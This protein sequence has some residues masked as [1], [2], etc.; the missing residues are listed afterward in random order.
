[1]PAV[2]ILGLLG[3]LAL[4]LLIGLVELPYQALSELG[5]QLQR[6]LWPLEGLGEAS[7]GSWWAVALVFGAT[8]ALV[9]L[10]AGPW[11]RGGGGGLTAALALQQ[12]SSEQ[13][14]GLLERIDLKTQ[15]YRLPLMALAH[16]GGLTVG[17]ESP[18]AA[19]G[20]SLVLAL[21]GRC[22]GL[23]HLPVK[24]LAAMGG[25]AGL[26][27][28]FRSPLLGALYV[29]EEL[30]REQAWS[31]VLPTL[32]LAGAGSLASSSLGQPARLVVVI[33]A[34]FPP[35]WW[36]WALVL[37][38]LA[39]VLGACFVRLLIPLARWMKTTL[40]RAPLATAIGVAFTLSMLAL[41]SGGLSLNDGSLSLAAALQGQSGGSALTFLWRYLAGL[42]SIA[43]GAPGGLMHDVMTLGALLLEPF[44]GLL[45]QEAFA[46]MAAIGAAALFAAA[47]GTPLFSGAFVFTLQ[48]NAQLLPWLLLASA[49]ASAIAEPLRG[50]EWN[51]YQV[52]VLLNPRSG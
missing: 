42:V 51:A 20:A 27:A 4:G 24:L 29:V 32:L 36:G 15:L 46:P 35:Q 22:P 47:N 39:A 25:G 3:L 9:L 45:P 49:L 21:R 26:G 19:L 37:I 23:G 2:G 33:Q 1:M 50:E 48:G 5:F 14:A 10:T 8:L 16:G 40:L 11:R 34:P 18:S 52:R 7:A 41:V 12:S 44:R 13:E 17:I 6:R 30:C 31:L 28:A 38:L 43:I